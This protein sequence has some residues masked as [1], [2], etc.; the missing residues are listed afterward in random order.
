MKNKIEDLKN[1]LFVWLETLQDMDEFRSDGKIDRE[2][3]EMIFK[4]TESVTAIADKSLEV[5]RIEQAEQK[6]RLE[7]AKL[8][9][10][11]GYEI[12]PGFLGLEDARETR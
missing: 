6:T 11:Y 9:F 3:A 1:A 2:K 4:R 10:E 5:K 12:K 8:A 7:A